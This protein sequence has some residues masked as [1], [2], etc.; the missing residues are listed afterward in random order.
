MN[1][2]S[3]LLDIM[4]DFNLEYKEARFL[5]KSQLRKSYEAGLIDKDTWKAA[6]KVLTEE[7]Q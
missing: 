5:L 3:Q 7:L 4:E 6:K 1:I 2:K